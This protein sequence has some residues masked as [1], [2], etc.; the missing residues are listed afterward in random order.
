MGIQEKQIR[1]YVAYLLGQDRN[2]VSNLG[3]GHSFLGFFASYL[4]I[5]SIMDESHNTNK[6]DHFH[7]KTISPSFSKLQLHF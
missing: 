3:L 1:G 4:D 7:S 2:C 6:K 5:L